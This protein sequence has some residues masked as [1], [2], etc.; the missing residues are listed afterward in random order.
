MPPTRP[1]SSCRSAGEFCARDDHP[2]P[3]VTWWH[4]FIRCLNLS[5]RNVI[6]HVDPSLR[7]AL[8]PYSFFPS[9]CAVL[10][11][12]L[13]LSLLSNHLHPLHFPSLRPLL[14]SLPFA[15]SSFAPHPSFPLAVCWVPFSYHSS[16]SFTVCILS[17]FLPYVPPLIHLSPFPHLIMCSLLISLPFPLTFSSFSF[18]VFPSHSSLSF[19]PGFP[20]RPFFLLHRVPLFTHPSPFPSPSVRGEQSCPS[21]APAP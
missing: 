13:S 4:A 10:P 1:S 7:V 3:V 6:T 2:S 15:L 17:F 16:F 8:L 20:F 5:P 18:T 19:L 14:L 11:S 12:L 21:F 9:P